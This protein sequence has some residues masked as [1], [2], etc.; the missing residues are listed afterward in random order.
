M[1]D[2]CQGAFSYY[3]GAAWI[4]ECSPM[5]CWLPLEGDPQYVYYW[6]RLYCGMWTT[7]SYSNKCS[8]IYGHLGLVSSTPCVANTG[9][10]DICQ[11]ALTRT[12]NLHFLT[13]LC[14]Q[15]QSVMLRCMHL[16]RR[17]KGTEAAM[18]WKLGRGYNCHSLGGRWVFAR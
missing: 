16:K 10:T 7:R 13:A 18:V 11:D 2:Q 8:G 9:N 5:M 1:T 14:L 15:W 3:T 6:C 4:N 12:V 17:S